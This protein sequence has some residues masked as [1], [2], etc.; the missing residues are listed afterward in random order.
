LRKIISIILLFIVFTGCNN[1]GLSKQQLFANGMT[2][3]ESG[4]TNGAIIAFK[5][6]IEKDQSYYEARYQLARAY[7]LQEKF[8]LARRELDK[9]LHLN[10]SLHDA[11]LSIAQIYINLGEMDD[12][13]KEIN[14][15]W[16]KS[17][18]N[19][20]E[21]FEISAVAYAFKRDFAKAE[22]L[23]NKAIEISPKRVS[24]KIALAKV[25][26]ANGKTSEAEKIIEEVLKQD[27]RDKKALYF[28]ASLKIEQDKVDDAIGIY[29]K[30]ADID[31]QDVTAKYQLGLNFLRKNQLEK[32][33]KIAAE[34]S[35]SFGKRPEGDYL[36]GIVNY[37]DREIDDAITSLQNALKKGANP[38][39]FYYMGLC[40]LLKGNAAQAT[41]AFQTTLDMRPDLVQARFLLAET[42]LRSGRT[43]P[44]EKEILKVL[45]TD[46]KNALAHNFLGSIYLAQG[47]GELAMD[48]FDR[49]LELNPKM[50]DIHLKKGAFNLL[51]GNSK[52]AEEE[53]MD[54][55]EI[56]PDVLQSRVVLARYY[57]LQ[58]DYDN[59]I[60]VL[61][62]G[63]RNKPNDA[64][65]LN[66]M[67]LA[68]MGKKDNDSAIRYF[69][70]A[71]AANP[72]FYLP[73]MNLA[74]YY[75]GKGENDKAT[76]EYQKI[77]E[78][79]GNNTG[80]MLALAGHME[81]NNKDKE[82]LTYY[83]KAKEQKTAVAFL[84]LA[85]Y[86]ERKKDIKNAVKVIDEVLDIEPKNI[87]AMIMKGHLHFAN[88]DYQRALAAYRQLES[89]SPENGAIRMAGVYKAMGDYDSAIEN[90]KTLLSKHPESA[91]MHTDL[92]R[93]YLKKKNYAKAEG[94]AQKIISLKPESDAGYLLVAEVY[95][96]ENRFLNAINVLKKAEQLNPDNVN[97][98]VALGK[99]Y[100]SLKD[101]GKALEISDKLEKSESISASAYFY[102]ASV[103]EITGK[104]ESAVKKHKKVLE[105][106]PDFIPSLNNLAYLYAEGYGPIDQAIV[107][108]Q[109]A[110]KLSPESAS[111]TDTL[112]WALYKKGS[113]D[114]AVKYFNEAIQYIPDNPSIQYHLGLAYLKKGMRVKA[115][116]HLNNAVRLGSTESFP[117]INDVRKLLKAI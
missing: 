103:L 3:L 47:K 38:W 25:H 13:I 90:L 31:P 18:D 45:E 59:A 89:I 63:L 50:A 87:K 76:K 49:A 54:A 6:A 23:L 78:I 40:H 36:M 42:H 83:L 8:M 106:S 15:Y 105:L 75:A 1:K 61:K 21:A 28:Q 67:G 73:Y 35:K 37:H 71:V 4:N 92:M 34:L 62:E 48:E 112:G 113:Y 77:L 70:K 95:I 64:I 55:V 7:I 68:Y 86:Y 10:P 22:D 108:A 20:P 66:L 33:R 51:S 94:T 117:E 11:H 109:K 102:Q 12:A 69:E 111:I 96:E 56:S 85:E 53:F 19:N 16:K 114:D 116:E 98:K 101:Y 30:I 91:D 107:M 115:E 65:L 80:A 58:R 46:E 99:T 57:V 52:K 39:A 41:S 32:A 88:K 74:A 81:R 43:E 110:K 9:V 72:R 100:I 82:A 93:L 97:T 2:F 84:A 27:S 29:E 79:D 104:K 5:K 17:S 14:L 44:A 26:R 24:A 60:K